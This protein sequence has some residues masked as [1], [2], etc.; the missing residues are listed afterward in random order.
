M[1][2][3]RVLALVS[4][5]IGA[6]AWAAYNPAGV[7]SVGT[8]A[9][10]QFSP[11]SSDV[12][13][14]FQAMFTAA[15]SNRG[16]NAGSVLLPCGTYNISSP[17][18]IS[19]ANLRGFDFGGE[20]EGCVVI[21]QLTNATPIF[22]MAS[23]SAP[24]INTVIRFHNFT[25]TWSNQQTNAVDPSNASVVLECSV[26]SGG[27]C[28]NFE[29]DHVFGQNGSR[30]LSADS[31]T[32]MWGINFHDN[33][34]DRSM[35]GAVLYM[36]TT[37]GEPRVT[38]RNN[39]VYVDGSVQKETFYNIFGTAQLLAENNEFNGATTT[40]IDAST[41]HL[42]SLSQSSGVISNLNVEF[43]YTQNNG[44]LI[45][46]TNGSG[47]T[48]PVH[49]HLDHLNL[50]VYNTNASVLYGVQGFSANTG[51]PPSLVM[52]IDGLT[53][54]CYS[55]CTGSFLPYT[56]NQSTEIP[57]VSEVDYLVNSVN[58]ALGGHYNP[59]S[60]LGGSYAGTYPEYDYDIQPANYTQTW[61]DVNVTLTMRSASGLASAKVNEFV[62][63]LSANRTITLPSTNFDDGTEFVIVRKATTPG[64]FTLTVVDPVSGNSCTF[65]NSTN[66]S[67]VYRATG[68]ATWIPIN[69]VNCN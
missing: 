24:Y 60:A 47:V 13:T 62:N 67:V 6:P 28:F 31:G 8:P 42:F 46:A 26:A 33:Y 54:N 12:T 30:M 10:F 23:S 57:W 56:A 48:P 29:M 14:Q 7:T 61:G 58:T 4:A 3:L 22:K 27:S 2:L 37:A 32:N 5:L 39:Y 51:A 63:Q 66:G 17:I 65:P 21:N 1:K 19:A 43:L 11:G 68:Y 50:G 36:P 9:Q 69:R 25:A 53:T 44:S 41:I 34:R 18:T 45:Y 38:I 64:A 59:N 16:L 15:A 49:L 52:T 20:A 55:T 35:T 40:P